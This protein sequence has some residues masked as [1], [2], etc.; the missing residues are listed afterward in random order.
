MKIK[1]ENNGLRD[2][3]N[4]LLKE[5]DDKKEEI[6]RMKKKYSSNLSIGL[7]NSACS[8]I[9]NNDDITQDQVD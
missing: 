6:L 8:G 3:N 7:T 2:I 1:E 4:K 5:I 9:L